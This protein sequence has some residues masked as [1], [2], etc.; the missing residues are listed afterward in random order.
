MASSVG[1]WGLCADFRSHWRLVSADRTARVARRKRS[2]A[3]RRRDSIRWTKKNIPLSRPWTSC[4][5]RSPHWRGPHLWPEFLG[6][7]CLV[8]VANNLSLQAAARREESPRSLGL[9]ARPLFRERFRVRNNATAWAQAGL[10]WCAFR[11]S[12][13]HPMP[14]ALTVSGRLAENSY[15]RKRRHDKCSLLR[16]RMADDLSRIHRCAVAISRRR[17][18]A[19]APNLGRRAYSSVREV[20]GLSARLRAD[21]ITD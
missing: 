9:D 11:L 16:R 18:C 8:A 21:Q 1:G 5:H 3:Q 13:V 14:T 20:H 12:P 15:D 10:P 7:R 4:R 2:G 17:A 19:A 6:L